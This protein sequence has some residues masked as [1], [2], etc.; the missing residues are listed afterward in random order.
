[1]LRIHPQLQ[2]SENTQ[3]L[4]ATTDLRDEALM[5]IH[6]EG[7]TFSS[8]VE[9]ARSAGGRNEPPALPQPNSLPEHT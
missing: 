8:A 2:T 4:S 1:M 6:L 3:D 5:G 7:C 9:K